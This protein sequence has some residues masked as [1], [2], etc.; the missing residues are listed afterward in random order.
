MFGRS[1]GSTLDRGRGGRLGRKR[2]RVQRR[3]PEHRRDRLLL[4]HVLTVTRR[5]L[6]IFAGRHGEEVAHGDDYVPANRDLLLPPSAPKIAGGVSL[7]EVLLIRD[8]NAD[9]VW[10]IAQIVSCRP[11]RS[12]E[13]GEG[14]ASVPSTFAA[15]TCDFVVRYSDE[16]HR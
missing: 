16:L 14:S 11:A 2:Q 13:P 6:R 1:A 12:C 7:E 9:L 15:A 5:R 10:G 3:I 4:G 8:E